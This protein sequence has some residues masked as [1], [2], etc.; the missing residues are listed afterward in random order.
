MAVP[1]SQAGAASRNSLRLSQ[2]R[3]AARAFMSTCSRRAREAMKRTSPR[4]STA[5]VTVTREM[6]SKS[7]GVPRVKRSVP[8]TESMPT[9]ATPRP[10][11][12]EARP[13]NRES[14]TTEEVAMKAKTAR[15]KNSAGPKWVENSASAGA[16]NTTMLEATMPPMNAPSEAVA[17]ACGAGP[18]SAILCPSKVE[19]MAEAWPGVFMR[20]AIVESPKRPPK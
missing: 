8:V 15:A 4:A 19:A 12:R 11:T 1:R 20:M 9:T 17:S 16:M 2:G 10:M 5:T 14:E 18:V 6:P 13:L 7:S 3:P